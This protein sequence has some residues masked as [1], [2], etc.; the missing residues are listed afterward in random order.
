MELLRF[1]ASL[2]SVSSRFEDRLHEIE[3]GSQVL[4]FAWFLGQKR[5]IGRSRVR[6]HPVRPWSMQQDYLT[7]H[8]T[9]CRSYYSYSMSQILVM[10][11]SCFVSS[12]HSPPHAATVQAQKQSRRANP[13][14]ASPCHIISVSPPI[15]SRTTPQA[16]IIHPR[17][18]PCL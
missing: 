3:L 17:K 2:I 8:I 14:H 5:S 7:R 12:I 13:E 11:V 9:D 10:I 16:R 18:H 6:T 1:F 15:Q 4:S